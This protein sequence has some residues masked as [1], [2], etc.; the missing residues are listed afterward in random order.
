VYPSGNGSASGDVIATVPATSTPPLAPGTLS[1]RVAGGL[2]LLSWDAA[3]GNATTYVIE[4]GTASGL[5]NVGTFATG[6]LDTTFS[7]PA[8]SGTYFVRLRAA[9]AFGSGPASNEVVVVVP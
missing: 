3:S 7:T 9:N 4:A 5:S 2:V 6:H 1:A 8:P